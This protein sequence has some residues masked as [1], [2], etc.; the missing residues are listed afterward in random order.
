MKIIRVENCGVRMILELEP[1]VWLAEWEGDP[2][3]T[4]IKAHAKR[5]KTMAEIGK[6]LRK[7]REYRPFVNARIGLE[8]KDEIN[9][10]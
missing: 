1:G 3:R 10:G 6:A 7:A 4:E 8:D 2:G 9:G 5:F